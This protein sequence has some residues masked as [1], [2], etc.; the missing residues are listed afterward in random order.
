[1]CVYVCKSKRQKITWKHLHQQK[2]VNRYNGT[3]IQYNIYV[4]VKKNKK[5]LHIKTHKI[6]VIYFNSK[7]QNIKQFVKHATIYVFK[8]KG[9]DTYIYIEYFCIYTWETVSVV[10]LQ[11]GKLVARIQGMINPLTHFLSFKLFLIF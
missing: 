6:F 5:T 2:T 8:R 7:K 4:G 9:W 11:G 3:T 10:Y 1:M